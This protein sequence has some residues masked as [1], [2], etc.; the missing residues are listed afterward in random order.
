METVLENDPANS[1]L[2]HENFRCVRIFSKF[3]PDFLKKSGRNSEKIRI[4]LKNSDEFPKKS[5]RNSEK[6]RMEL[7]KNLDAS[8]NFMTKLAVR[9][10]IFK[11]SFHNYTTPRRLKS[12][13]RI[14]FGGNQSGFLSGYF[15]TPLRFSRF[16]DGWKCTMCPCRRRTEPTSAKW[17]APGPG[18]R[19]HKAPMLMIVL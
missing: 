2:C 3:H 7:W 17:T 6:I 9:S 8:E 16:M 15:W 18:P 11:D 10:I 12:Q 5:G 13:R 1:Q 19:G 4:F 14:N